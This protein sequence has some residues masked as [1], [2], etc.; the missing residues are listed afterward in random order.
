VNATAELYRLFYEY[1][2][3]ANRQDKYTIWQKGDELILDLLEKI[4]EASTLAADRQET[5]RAASRKLNFLR[6][7]ILILKNIGSLNQEKIDK[8][9]KQIDEIGR[10]LGGWIKT[11]K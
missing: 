3:N 7:F 9:Q 10:M 5:L 8:L 2:R 4:I 6:V 1:R 11:T